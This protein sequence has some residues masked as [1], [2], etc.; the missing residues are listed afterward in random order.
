MCSNDFTDFIKFHSLKACFCFSVFCLLEHFLDIP[1]KTHKFPSYNKSSLITLIKLHENWSQLQTSI[2]SQVWI[3][4][5]T[6]RRTNIH[7]GSIPVERF[8]TAVL[9][10][11]LRNPSQS[12]ITG[13][14]SLCNRTLRFKLPIH[15]KRVLPWC[16][17]RT[18]HHSESEPNQTV[19]ACCHV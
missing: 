7:S 14:K 1:T 12:E 6:G 4:Q 18:K 13:L 3:F 2:W 8:H 17:L 9:R 16:F 10:M 19:S 5:H 11:M 15:T